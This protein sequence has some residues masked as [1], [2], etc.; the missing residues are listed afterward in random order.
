[1]ILYH[2][3]LSS[4]YSRL[5]APPEPLRHQ[6]MLSYDIHVKF[7]AR[8]RLTP[9]VVHTNGVHTALMKV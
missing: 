4:Y 7:L 6:G 5:L 1:M 8:R 9:N 3:T 2:A